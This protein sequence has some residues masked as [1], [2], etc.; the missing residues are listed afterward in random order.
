MICGKKLAY[1]GVKPVVC[2][3]QQCVFSYEQFGLGVDI[4]SEISKH[5]DIVDLMITFGYCACFGTKQDF[6][7]FEPYPSGIELK[8]VDKE[9]GKT[10]TYDFKKSNET[11]VS[12][13]KAVLEKFPPV[14][15]LQKWVEKGILKEQLFKIHPLAYPLLRWLVASNRCHLKKLTKDEQIKEMNTE[16]QYLLMSGTPEKEKKFQS[17]KQSKG[18]YLGFHGSAACNWHSIMRVGLKNMSGSKGQVNGAAYGNG[19]YLANDANTSFSYLKYA[20]MWQ[21][22]MFSEKSNKLGVMA[23]CEIIKDTSVK[24]SPYYVVPDDGLIATR[25]FFIY[26]GSGSSSAQ[27]KT[28]KLP[29]VKF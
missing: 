26:P 18:T 10:T 20:D 19:V 16:H 1:A 3:N 4:E 25:Y 2:E 22:S 6:S 14:S 8:L 29:P 15:D 28:L 9:S 17:L 11:D 5:P 24:T 21:K 23:L 7:P 27:G 13:V 12:K